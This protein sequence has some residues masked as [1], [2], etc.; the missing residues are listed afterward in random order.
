MSD[1]DIEAALDIIDS[2]DKKT[3]YAIIEKEKSQGLSV[4]DLLSLVSTFQASQKILEEFQW[5]KT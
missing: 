5:K 2:L 1:G 4:R 3:K